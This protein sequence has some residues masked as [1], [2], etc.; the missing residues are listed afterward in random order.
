M[1]HLLQTA[2]ALQE[3]LLDARLA[4]TLHLL[5]LAPPAL[6]ASPDA[7]P[8]PAAAAPAMLQLLLLRTA[9]QMSQH[10]VK[11]SHRWLK[12]QHFAS[13]K[14]ARKLSKSNICVAVVTHFLFDAFNPCC[15]G[16]RSCKRRCCGCADACSC[17]GIS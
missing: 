16:V 17:T 4:C 14:V 5:Q 13:C 12:L 9:V 11:V 7:L 10:R 3:G 8:A 15:I 1:L 2:L 6:A